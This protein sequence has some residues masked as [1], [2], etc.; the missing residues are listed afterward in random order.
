MLHLIA[1][2]EGDKAKY[3]FPNLKDILPCKFCR[4]STARFL[5]EMPPKSPADRWLYDFHNRVNKKLRDQCKEDPRVI[6]PPPDPSFEKVSAHY[7]SLLEKEPDAPP[8]M[9]F[10]F[11]IAYNYTSEKESIYRHFFAMLAKHYSVSQA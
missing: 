5:E 1:H 4:E 10:L 2:Y 7:E 8:G 11:C 6:C 3:F 9:D